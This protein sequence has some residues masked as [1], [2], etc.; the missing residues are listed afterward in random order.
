MLTFFSSKVKL[1]LL[2]HASPVPRGRCKNLVNRSHVENP[3][4]LAKDIANL[5]PNVTQINITQIKITQIKLGCHFSCKMSKQR[6]N[7]IL[8]QKSS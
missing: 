1:R 2:T 4:S 8:Q 5:T 3:V 6:V 7:L